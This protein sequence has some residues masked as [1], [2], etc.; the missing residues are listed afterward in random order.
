V[1]YCK[2][3]EKVQR[4]QWNGLERSNKPQW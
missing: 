2:H 3:T 1:R 4:L